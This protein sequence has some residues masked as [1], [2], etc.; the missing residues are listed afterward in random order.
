[1]NSLEW[2]VARKR[3]ETKLELPGANQTALQ[4]RTS[5]FQHFVML[6]CLLFMLAV[7][8]LL[9]MTAKCSYREI[10]RT[11]G[12]DRCASSPNYSETSK[13]RSKVVRVLR[14]S[15]PL[16]RSGTESLTSGEWQAYFFRIRDFV[17]SISSSHRG[18]G[19]C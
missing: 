17:F 16:L 1:M 18:G 14:M 6:Y 7:Y 2:R 15:D 11:K 12:P 13:L 3:C 9:S 4:T 5:E 19:C 10:T 8:S